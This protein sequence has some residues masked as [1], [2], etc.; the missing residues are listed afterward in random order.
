MTRRFRHSLNLIPLEDRLAPATMSWHGGATPPPGNTDPLYGNR[1]TNPA[2]WYG[3][4]VPGAN[5]VAVFDPASTTYNGFGQTVQCIVDAPATVGGITI[6]PPPNGIQVDTVQIP[7]TLTTTGAS[8]LNS[9][10]ITGGG[11]WNNQGTVTLSS[12]TDNVSFRWITVNNS[13]SFVHGS[14]K[15]LVLETPFDGGG[16]PVF[17]NLAGGLFEFQNDGDI[18]GTPAPGNYFGTFNNAGTVRRT[19]GTGQVFITGQ[20]NNSGGAWDIQSGSFT[21]GPTS[22]G[23]FAGGTF[24]VATGASLDLLGFNGA[25][26]WTGSFS[27]SGAGLILQSS[28]TMTIGP[29]GAT[30]NFP[31]Y[32]LQNGVISGSGRLDFSGLMTFIGTSGGLNGVDFHNFGTIVHNTSNTLAISSGAILTNESAGVIDFQGDGR[33]L[34]STTNAGTINNK[35]MIRKSS[36]TGNSYIRGIVNNQ[37]GTWDSKSGNL[38]MSSNGTHTGGTFNASAGAF[39]SLTDTRNAT[40]TGT[41]TGTGAGNVY[42]SQGTMTIGAAG[43]TFNFPAGLL[44]W[45]DGTVNGS[46]K[47]TNTGAIT[48]AS[49]TG[50]V[51]L[52]GVNLSNSGS[53]VHATAATLAMNSGAVLTN[54]PAGVIDFQGDGDIF[55]STTNAGTID[56]KGLIRKSS[57]TGNSYV[58][59]IINNQG[60][61]WDS[62]SG[63]LLMS[64]N[65]THTGGTFNASAGAFVSLTDTR[66]A[67]WTGTYTGTG[68]G[69]VYLSQGTMTIG[70][71]GA[72]FNFPAGLLNWYDGTVNGSGKLTNTGAITIASTTSNVYLSGLNFSNAGTI[73]HASTRNFIITA[74]TVLTNEATGVFDYQADGNIDADYFNPAS[75]VNKGLIKKSAGTGTSGFFF[76]S[77]TNSGTI[78]VQTGTIY[79]NT[80]P[81][82]TFSGALR[83][84]GSFAGPT[85]NNSSG[86]VLPGSSPGLLSIN[87]YQ[88][89]GTGD[90][91]IDLA[92]TSPGTQYDQLAVYGTVS[93]GGTLHVALGFVP[94]VNDT[95]TII[96]N[97]GTNDKVTGEFNGLP[98]GSTI[99]VNGVNL[100]INYNGGDGN[101]VTLKAVSTAAT[102]PP[103]VAVQINDGSAQRSMVTSMKV[104]FSQAVVLGGNPFTL[105]RTGPGSPAGNVTVAIDLSQST[106]NQTIAVLT[107]TG[108]YTN[109]R[110][111]MDGRYDLT[112][113]AANVVGL[114]GPLDGN[115]NGAG[116]DDYTEVGAPGSGLNLFRLFGDANGDGTVAA[117]DFLRFRIA[118]GTANAD[119]DA[120]GDGTVSSSDFLNF[121]LRFGVTI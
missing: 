37:G 83:G 120:D 68:A 111:L 95:F 24:K 32:A 50:T 105:T 87:S 59:G 28:G 43:A 42:L 115:G 67:T 3:G 119:F 103:T 10:V 60:G 47:L 22:G 58:R 91:R 78:D 121:R 4:V 118:F 104:T 20:V 54:E 33:I 97:D 23:T 45:Y 19:A 110:S 93:L 34:E 69:N 6:V 56:N 79:L 74:G 113:S 51:Y 29:A 27:G 76:G 82:V 15:N 112:I 117:S 72:T 57:G 8:L 108:P 63:N 62:K 13:G 39:V 90:L 35:G 26:T 65:G 25:S 61:T 70:A 116:G 40:W 73:V 17:N 80:I 89:S 106:A 2:N 98:D 96:N 14:V 18:A 53:I 114:G 85:V 44:N 11:T 107:F 21:L 16:F 46:G 49:T 100:Q 7:T 77:L 92:G 64:S 36:G 52:S 31:N 5:D 86:Q 55:E 84:N 41:Y 102:A 101:D 9:G 71:A 88:Q 94:A 99:S 38:L 109:G 48:I 12:A 1:W 66:N 30:F 81:T 75:M